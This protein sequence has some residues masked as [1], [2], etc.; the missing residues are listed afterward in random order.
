MVLYVVFVILG[1]F[2]KFQMEC[3]LLLG[4]SLEVMGKNGVEL[5]FRGIERVSV[6][7][8]TVHVLLKVC[9]QELYLFDAIYSP[10]V[11]HHKKSINF[12]VIF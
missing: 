9:A 1:F 10:G 5:G 6:C 7:S 4:E 12:L 2:A 11:R 8:L 3:R